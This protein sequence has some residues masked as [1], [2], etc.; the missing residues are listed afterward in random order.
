M[1]INNSRNWSL[2][3]FFF[4]YLSYGQNTNESSTTYI[5]QK[6]PGLTPEIFAP[7]LISNPDEYEFGS[8]FTEDG[9]SFF[10]GVD[11]GGRSEIRFTSLMGGVWSEPVALLSHPSYGFNDPMLSPDEQ[12]LFFIS[13][14]P[15][16]NQKETSDI[17][18][19]YVERE[20]K[21]WSEPINAGNYI[22][23]SKNEYYISFTDRGDMYFSS[24]GLDMKNGSGSF[25]IYK[26]ELLNGKYQTPSKLPPTINSNQY[27]ADVFI[28]PDESYII[29]CGRRSDGLG[30]GDLYISF[31]DDNGNWSQ[32][33]NMGNPIN[34]EFHQLCPFVSKDG[35]YLFFTSNKDIYWV[36]ASIIDRYRE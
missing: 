21:G 5:G 16:G 22:N 14:K 11:I 18:I 1:L 36:D 31:R 3:L 33:Q 12:K 23:T 26:S 6:A 29:F 24:N 35:K 15:K 9:L 8:V 19:W 30:R 20:G 2:I 27:E 13:N 10:Y 7:S 34:N 17:D 32:S 4:S 25:D 28:A